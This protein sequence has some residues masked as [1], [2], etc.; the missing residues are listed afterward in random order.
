MANK[1]QKALVESLLAREPGNSDDVTPAMRQT[2]WRSFDTIRKLGYPDEGAAAN[3]AASIARGDVVLLGVTG[4]LASGK[5]TVAP[6]VFR[7][8]GIDPRPPAVNHHYYA[9]ALKEEVNDLIL[10]PLRYAPSVE[11]GAQAVAQLTQAPHA[12][13]FEIAQKIMPALE[14]DPDLHA[15]RRTPEIRWLLQL[16]GTDVRRNQD[17]D[18]W[19]KASLPAIVEHA[20]RPSH[21]FITDIRFPN[22]VQVA[23]KLGFFVARLEVSDKMQWARMSARDKHITRKDFDAMNRHQ[24]ERALDGYEGFDCVVSNDGDVEVTAEEIAHRYRMWRKNR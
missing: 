16:W 1:D 5:D 8:L 21:V 7:H 9:R 18:Y 20:A 14:K 11:E 12:R 13:A 10:L 15:R 24:S 22:E 2:F 23:Q 17:V 6:E 3:A 4:R 19:V